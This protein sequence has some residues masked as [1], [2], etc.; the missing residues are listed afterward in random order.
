MFVKTVKSIDDIYEE[1]EVLLKKISIMLENHSTRT[2]TNINN[3]KLGV[4]RDML[5][6]YIA[7]DITLQ[8]EEILS[9]IGFINKMLVLHNLF[10]DESIHFDFN[11]LTKLIE[12]K[13]DVED[14]NQDYN[15]T[16]FEL[17]MAV[18]AAKMCNKT[19][20]IDMKTDCDV[21]I[22]QD[23]AIECKYLH[24]KK[25]IRDN[26]KKGFQQIEKR[27]SDNLAKQGFIAVDITYL[28]SKDRVKKFAD[29]TLEWYILNLSD[30]RMSEEDKFNAVIR[31][32]NYIKTVMAYATNEATV[33]VCNA[34]D[35]FKKGQDSLFARY[36]NSV[37]GVTCQY[38]LP[39]F[40][41]FKD[42]YE[43]IHLRSM[44]PIVNPYLNR[45]DNDNFIEYLKKYSTG[46]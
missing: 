13:K 33:M 8:D 29:A 44:E 27:I 12:R 39:I 5:K 46:F 9:L 2:H 30:I 16:Y 24:S 36:S 42:F 25:G 45:N 41:E 34:L 23:M 1:Y 14:L 31:N 10:D 3:T 21:I 6:K 32:K 35:L 43:P 4:M 38:F 20:I 17:S 28:C 26:I 18:R 37:K 7:K 22:D 11:E 19:S 15:N 40:I